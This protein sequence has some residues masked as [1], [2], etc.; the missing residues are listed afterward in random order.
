MATTFRPTLL[1]IAYRM[2]GEIMVSEDIVQDVLLSWINDTP[3]GVQNIKAWLARSV[4]NASLNHL[5]RV[6]R[7][8]ETYK[9]TWLP[10]P[11]LAGQHAVDARLDISYGFMLL[12][13][14]LSPLERAVFVL[15]ESFDVTYAEI[16]QAFDTTE[17]NCRQLYKRAKEKLAGS[18]RRF[19]P[20][21][22]QQQALLTAF[23]SASETGDINEFIRLLK[24][25]VVL[26]SD[27]GGKVVAAMNTLVGLDVVGNFLRS[28]EQKFGQN[29]VVKPALIN[30][31]VALLFTEK[32][33]QQ[34]NTIMVMEMD[35]SG[36]HQL[37]SVRNP[38]K[39]AHLH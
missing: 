14:K 5:A 25:D 20:D 28:V 39:L 3:E 37:F 7:Q 17:A 30:G 23:T 35:D 9:G 16:T 11:V 6:K 22:Q 10:E 38:D 12:L 13:G 33:T 36:I 19:S 32:D 29:L 18:K 21:P 26:Y 15:K 4:M 34:L 2:T 31:Q 1:S 27:G 24:N 8:R